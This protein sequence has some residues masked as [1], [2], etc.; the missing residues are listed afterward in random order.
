MNTMN[1]E[2]NTTPTPPVGQPIPIPVA[3][4]SADNALVMGV[5]AYLSILVI[6]PLLVAKD[7]PF[8]K[9]HIKQG[10]LLV[11]GQVVLWMLSNVLY[12]MMFYMTAPIFMI[13]NFGLIVLSIIGIINVIKKQEKELPVLGSLAVHLPL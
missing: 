11:I 12:S 10:L 7:N 3:P 2:E 1:P 5:L 6:I 9:F 4:S 8:V 13:A